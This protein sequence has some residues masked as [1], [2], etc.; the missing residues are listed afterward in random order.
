MSGFL[1]GFDQ[2]GNVVSVTDTANGSLVFESVGNQP[3]GNSSYSATDVSGDGLVV[4][5]NASD[6]EAFSW[7]DGNTTVL[8]FLSQSSSGS[9]QAFGTNSDGSVVVGMSYYSAFGAP[10]YA[11]QAFRSVDGTMSGLGFLSG[12]SG[13]KARQC[14]EC[15]GSVVVVGA[16]R[17]MGDYP[18][19]RY[20]HSTGQRL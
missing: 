6:S 18:G 4:V 3:F 7:S 8:G 20:R 13:E 15:D 11:Y 16:N 1:Y 10:N 5:G 17:H 14:S 12:L 9:T 19:D 2:Y